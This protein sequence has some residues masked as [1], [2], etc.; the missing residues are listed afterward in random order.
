MT[1]TTRVAHL[2][3][4]L[5][6]PA[7]PGGA[8]A[9]M[10]FPTPSGVVVSS[11]AVDAKGN[12]VVSDSSRHQLLAFTPSGELLFVVGNGIPGFRGNRQA[13]S[14][15][16]L[17]SPDGLTYDA[18]GNLYFADTGNHRVRKIT[19]DG[20]ITTIAG[21]GRDGFGGDGGAATSAHLNRPDDVAVDAAGNIYIADS[22]NHR[23]RKV[24]PDGKIQ[25]IAGRTP[26]RGETVSGDGGQA[27]SAVLSYPWSVAVDRS[28]AVYFGQ[29]HGLIRR[30]TPDG[31]IDRVAGFYKDDKTTPATGDRPSAIQAQL[32]SADGLALD[33]NGVLYFTNLRSRGVLRLRSDGTI[34]SI[35]TLPAWATDITFDTAG[36]L[37]MSDE[38]RVYK[39]TNPSAV[40]RPLSPQVTTTPPARGPV[41]P[42]IP[43]TLLTPAPN[44]VLANGC[45][46]QTGTHDWE[47]RWSAVPGA[48]AYH[49]HV[50]GPEASRAIVDDMAVTVPAFVLRARGYVA[51][52]FQRGW[53]WRVRAKVGDVWSEWS[54]EQRFDVEPAV[55]DCR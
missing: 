26:R 45:I 22:F 9:L 35:A 24:T 12:V 19:P 46:N 43:P 31:R 49:L 50:I 11:L 25:T 8:Q 15:A 38:A 39:V 21:N 28:G 13:A 52:K 17:H 20:V 18:S 34:E 23:I 5:L 29:N 4:L 51:E 1:I 37:F 44:A 55:T 3:L 32:D 27:T 54:G 2:L 7:S 48:T 40:T 6:L 47:F 30:V 14:D 16:Q 33:A 53:T 36:Q 42:A 41:R 10:P